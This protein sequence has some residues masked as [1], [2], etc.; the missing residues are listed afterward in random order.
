MSGPDLN[1]LDHLRD[2]VTALL[3]E[4]QAVVRCYQ[5]TGDEVERM[6][7]M[8]RWLK[9]LESVEREMEQ[10]AYNDRRAGKPA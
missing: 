7:D 4:R 5:G 9:S 3:S 10:V 6:N 1:A 2:A 8:T